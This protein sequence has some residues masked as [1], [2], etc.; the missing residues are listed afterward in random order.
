MT[1]TPVGVTGPSVGV[2]SLLSSPQGTA[3]ADGDYFLQTTILQ[4][5][6]AVLLVVILDTI[7]LP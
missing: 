7:L 6:Q 4:T 3:A 2:P 5:K 1:V